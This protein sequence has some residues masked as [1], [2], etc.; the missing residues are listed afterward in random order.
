MKKQMTAVT[1]WVDE[2]TTNLAD[3]EMLLDKE[4]PDEIPETGTKYMNWE[5][6]K[7]FDE[8]KVAVF[9]GR[10]VTYNFYTF[11]VD[12]IPGCEEILDDGTYTKRGFVIPYFSAGKVR[13][14]IDNNLDYL[15]KALKYRHFRGYGQ[16]IYYRFTTFTERALICAAPREPDARRGRHTDRPPTMTIS[17]TDHDGVSSLPTRGEKGRRFF[18]ALCYAVGA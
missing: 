18:Y 2:K 6:N 15:C 10:Q 17:Y 16:G 1:R 9:Y 14:I 3:I 11:S 4:H 8:D 13:Y 7:V 5:I 12:Q